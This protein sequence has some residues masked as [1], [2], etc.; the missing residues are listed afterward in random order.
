MANEYLANQADFETVANAI[1]AKGGTTGGLSFPDGFA[2]AVEAI[3]TTPTLQNKTVTPGTSQQSVTADSGYD[4]LGTVTVE[5]DANLKTENIA[6]GV[7]IFGVA[8]S[9]TPGSQV[10]S[11]TVKLVFSGKPL[12]ITVNTGFTVREML[13]FESKYAGSGIVF[14]DGVVTRYYSG[15]NGA[16][17]QTLRVS[18]NGTTITITSSASQTFSGSYTFEYIA[19]S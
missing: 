3:K 6:S 1:R 16:V 2:E 11:G 7:S 13:I 8:G 15:S 4:G 17:T 18:Q 5:G 14:R 19:I 10:V 9:L 12:T